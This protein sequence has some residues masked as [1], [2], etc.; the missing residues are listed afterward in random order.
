MYRSEVRADCSVSHKAEP[1][2]LARLTSSLE[3]EGKLGS[4]AHP[5]CWYNPVLCSCSGS[6]VPV[7]L[8]LS[9]RDHSCCQRP[10]TFLLTWAPASA[11]QPWFIEPFSCFEPPWPSLL[12]TAK[13]SSP[14][15]RAHIYRVYLNNPGPSPYLK[16]NLP[17]N[18]T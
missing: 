5:G 9:S 8:R 18:V 13:E 6:E 4:Q 1:K 10:L 16:I 12:P 15:S 3:A 2:V 14:L 7:S 11:N 17:R